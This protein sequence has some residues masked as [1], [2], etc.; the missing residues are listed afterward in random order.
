ALDPVEC[1][2]GAEQIAGIRQSRFPYDLVSVQVESD[3][4]IFRSK[5][6]IRLS[7]GV[8]QLQH[9]GLN[10]RASAVGRGFVRELRDGEPTIQ[11]DE[12]GVIFKFAVRGPFHADQL[13]RQNREA[14]MRGS[15]HRARIGN[16]VITA[17]SIR[18][19]NRGV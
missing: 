7:G 8:N 9:A 17:W 18:G 12:R 19:F 11:K 15:D 10:Y 16:R 6:A 13:R 1:A 3:A 5:S 4:E 14:C 2:R